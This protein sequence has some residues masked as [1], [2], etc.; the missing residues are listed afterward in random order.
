MMGSN[1]LSFVSTFVR[2]NLLR[3]KG[4]FTGNLWERQKMIFSLLSLCSLAYA[5][6]LLDR[7]LVY[8]RVY[9]S[10]FQ[11]PHEVTFDHTICFSQG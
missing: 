11:D 10:P 9:R 4:A 6:K 5:T 7:N 2:T 8:P 1:Q 3:Y